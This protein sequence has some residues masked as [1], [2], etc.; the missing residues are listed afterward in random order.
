MMAVETVLS[1]ISETCGRHGACKVGK[2]SA[3]DDTRCAT[4]RFGASVAVSFNV[5]A[6]RNGA[7]AETP[8]LAGTTTRFGVRHVSGRELGLLLAHLPPSDLRVNSKVTA[9]DAQKSS[10]LTRVVT[11]LRIVS[12]F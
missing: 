7:T 1:T 10:I 12:E 4:G 6:G 8:V 3:T 11:L 9:C 5:D 2:V